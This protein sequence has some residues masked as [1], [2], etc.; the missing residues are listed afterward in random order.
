MYW[1]RKISV[2]MISVKVNSKSELVEDREENQRYTVEF[3]VVTTG[4]CREL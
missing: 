1:G 2:M 4:Y 3:V